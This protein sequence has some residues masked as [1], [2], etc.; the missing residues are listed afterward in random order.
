MIT[1]L[2]QRS[3]GYFRR[4][5]QLWFGPCDSCKRTNL[6]S[7]IPGPL[8]HR[9]RSLKLP[10]SYLPNN[11]AGLLQVLGAVTTLWGIYLFF[12]LPDSPV[13]ARFFDERQKAIA[14][15][16]VAEN[17]VRSPSLSSVQGTKSFWP[18]QTGIKNKQFKMYQVREAFVDP[19]TYILFLASIAAQIPNGVVS[20]FSRYVLQSFVSS[21]FR[22][23][24]VTDHVPG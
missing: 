12:M 10:R 15:K 8:A 9:L 13:N 24:G 23:C 6:G 16:R 11:F 5:P 21:L 18:G 4:L 17:R 19:K 1:V 20:N 22:M 2:L 3:G 7:H 14:V